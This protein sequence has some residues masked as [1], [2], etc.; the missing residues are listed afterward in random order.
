MYPKSFFLHTKDSGFSH[1]AWLKSSRLALWA[2]TAQAK[3]GWQRIPAWNTARPSGSFQSCAQDSSTA[4]GKRIQEWALIE[5]T[6]TAG[7]KRLHLLFNMWESSK[8]RC[9]GEGAQRKKFRCI[10]QIGKLSWKDMGQSVA[11]LDGIFTPGAKHKNND[12][13]KLLRDREYPWAIRELPS[14]A[15]ISAQVRTQL[16]GTHTRS[17]CLLYGIFSLFNLHTAKS[18]FWR[19]LL[20]RDKNMFS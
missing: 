12:L 7:F 8:E 14:V 17:H 2:Q 13:G 10:V 6:R 16:W 19:K 1:P 18:A 3:N 20:G 11:S 4:I 9:V 5:L 15:L